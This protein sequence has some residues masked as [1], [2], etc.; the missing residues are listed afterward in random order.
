M[1][2]DPR[3]AQNI[4]DNLKDVLHYDINFFDTKGI[5]TASTDSSRIGTYH[6]AACKAAGSGVTIMVDQDRPY[7]GARD[8][9]NVPVL[10]NDSVVA[11][12][13]ITGPL[14]EVGSLGRIIE[15]M[16]EILL[17]AN[18]EQ[19]TRFNR[20]I[21]TGNL[22][23]LL[24]MEHKDDGL[25]EA[26]SMTVDVDLARPRSAL[27]GFAPGVR[28]ERLDQDN[29]YDRLCSICLSFDAPLF[30]VGPRDFRIFIHDLP[31]GTLKEFAQAL[32]TGLGE[33]VGS[34][35]LLGMGRV[36]SHPQEYWRSYDQ[37]CTVVHWTCFAGMT[38]VHR[39][40]DLDGGLIIPALPPALAEEFVQHVFAG[41][42]E[43]RIDWFAEIFHAYTKHNG[44]ITHAAQELFIHKNTMQNRL[45]A[46]AK[47]TGYNPRSL[48]DYPVLEAAFA[49]REYRA[50]E[51]NM[52][53]E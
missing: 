26:L 12:I 25:M 31:S 48:K 51:R 34:D 8:G 30:A 20:R 15:K 50:F 37:A 52:N 14:D 40:D 43:E 18:M 4:V 16:T 1:N 2:I 6:D 21:M 3:I 46:L 53:Q 41:M 5:M 19:I 49:I 44:S 22:V 36:M 23:N 32:Q 33:A 13:G 28:L 7:Q 11:V 29:L 38:G 42:K 24:T 10:F 17:R 45:D 27:V 47:E 9:V 39:Y 35:V